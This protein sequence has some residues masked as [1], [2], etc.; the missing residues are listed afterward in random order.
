MGSYFAGTGPANG[1]EIPDILE[2][3]LTTNQYSG[4]AE[5]GKQKF[6]VSCSGAASPRPV[7][8]KQRADG[9]WFPHEWS[10]LVTGI[11]PPH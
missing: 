8:V 6:F 11:I 1:Y 3:E 7:T 4:N 5:D 9:S 2:I 10:S